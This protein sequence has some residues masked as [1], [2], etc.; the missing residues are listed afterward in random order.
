M[1]SGVREEGGADLSGVRRQGKD[2]MDEPPK[3]A[4]ARS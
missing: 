3:D 2:D 4:R 1:G